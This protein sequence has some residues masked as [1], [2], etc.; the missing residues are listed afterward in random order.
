MP[1]GAD[2]SS[3]YRVKPYWRRSEKS[4]WY[5]GMFS[6]PCFMHGVFLFL[7]EEAMKE[8]PKTYDPKTVESDIYQM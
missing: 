7:K 4:G 1:V 5:R 3:R 6:A 2:G 8:L